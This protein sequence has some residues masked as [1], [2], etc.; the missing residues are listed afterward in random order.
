[1]TCHCGHYNETERQNKKQFRLGAGECLGVIDVN[2]N[3]P[4]FRGV[5]IDLLTHQ[6]QGYNCEYCT[7]TTLKLV[8]SA[9]ANGTVP[10]YKY[11]SQSTG[12]KVVLA[13]VEGR[14]Y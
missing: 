11:E 3:I 14:F 9:K 8:A 7:M 13:N 10:V 12:L 1:M 4:G 6:F 5:S 2:K